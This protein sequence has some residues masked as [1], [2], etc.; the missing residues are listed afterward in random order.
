MVEIFDRG[1]AAISSAAKETFFS[2]VRAKTSM[3]S[4][5]RG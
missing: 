4:S 3:R 5:L 1:Q 2:R